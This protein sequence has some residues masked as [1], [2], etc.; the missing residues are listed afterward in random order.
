LEVKENE[1]KRT[2][3]VRIW[4]IIVWI[5]ASSIMIWFMVGIGQQYTLSL[6][7]PSSKVSILDDTIL[8]LPA[9]TICNWNQ[10]VGVPVG[11]CE[12]CK[13]SLVS[14]VNITTTI[15]NPNGNADC[16]AIWTPIQ[17]NT[18][19]GL[20][21]CYVF[22]DDKTNV[23]YSVATGYSGAMATI[24]G[25]KPLP[26]TDPPIN[27]AAVQATYQVQGNTNAPVIVAEI[28]FAP[29]G[30]DTFFGLQYINT[31]H[32]ELS[33]TNPIY[34]TSMYSKTNSLVK[35]QET[36]TVDIDYV[37]VSFSFETLSVQAIIFS[38]DY[39]LLNFFGDFAGMVGTLMGLDVIKVSIGIPT[40]YF[41]YKFKACWPLEEVFNG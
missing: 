24:W 30:F 22:N 11:S 3:P 13:L 26:M 16:S 10:E 31:V 6:K 25:I 14:C 19:I 7:N 35:L 18:S 28:E 4:M 17:W 2:L 32:S 29:S 21:Y 9:V 12:E 36:P 20:F 39:T 23:V 34:N 27:R 8:P 41:A 33:P 37:G 1:F 5:V 38:V 40:A 15:L